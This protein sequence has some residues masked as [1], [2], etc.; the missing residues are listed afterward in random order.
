MTTARMAYC[1][2][3]SLAATAC[4]A[5]LA[6]A[7]SVS[8]QFT[9]TGDVVTPGTYNLTTLSALP[10][11]VQTAT[12]TAAG[13]PVTDTYTGTNLWTLLNA[14]GGFTPAPG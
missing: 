8:P 3:L 5:D 4:G 2:A 13:S 14:A 9:L 7:G 6:M 12:Y 1:I 11:T 10:P